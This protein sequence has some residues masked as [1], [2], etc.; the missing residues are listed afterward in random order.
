[1]RFGI[2]VMSLIAASGAARRVFERV[3]S[4]RVGGARTMTRTSDSRHTSVA[5]HARTT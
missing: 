3:D 4:G 2:D 5:A 1:L